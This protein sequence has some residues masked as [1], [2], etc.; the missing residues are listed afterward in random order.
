MASM[1]TYHVSKGPFRLLDQQFGGQDFMAAYDQ[2]LEG[3][4]GDPALGS[5]TAAETLSARAGSRVERGGSPDELSSAQR[6][7]F[8]ND[9]LGRWW[10]DLAVADTLRLGVIEAIT[11]AK[12]ANDGRG[13]PIEFY[14][15]CIEQSLFQ[16]YFS[17]GEH[18]VTVLILTPSP[19]A[20]YDSGPLNVGESLWVVKRWDQADDDY[21]TINGTPAGTVPLPTTIAERTTSG[22]PGK[23]I[24]RQI[25][26]G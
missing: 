6:D 24:K 3:T 18:Q 15:V 21:S 22:P 26:H 8:I 9:W 20:D 5:G 16:V 14:W 2:V 7:H 19:P 12:A 13:L 4:K 17:Q 11:C 25:W 10:P 23:M 1:P